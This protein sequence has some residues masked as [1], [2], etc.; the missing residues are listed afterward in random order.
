[1]SSLRKWR[2]SLSG[3]ECTYA[4]CQAT[5]NIFSLGQRFRGFA[6]SSLEHLGV[7]GV[8]VH[9]IHLDPLGIAPPPMGLGR[10]GELMQKLMSCCLFCCEQ[11]SPLSLAQESHVFCQHPQ[12]CGGIT[13][14][15]ANRITS[16]DSSPFLTEMS[17]RHASGDVG[18]WVYEF[19]V[20]G[21]RAGWAILVNVCLCSI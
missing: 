2:Y 3:A 16:L 19:G 14:Y 10:P 7:H 9:G 8:L 4:C 18:K 5:N 17:I 15:L 11:Q 12:K 13:R 20:Q 1:M 6:Y 21:S